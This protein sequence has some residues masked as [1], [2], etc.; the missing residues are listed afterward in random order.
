[1]TRKKNLQADEPRFEYTEDRDEK[2]KEEKTV[3]GR[4]LIR[5]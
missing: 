4:R 1:M 2:K 3:G 5:E